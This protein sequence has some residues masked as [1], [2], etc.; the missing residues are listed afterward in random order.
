MDPILKVVNI[1]S[2]YQKHL[3]TE[4]LQFFFRY[5]SSQ[6]TLLTSQKS[7]YLELPIYFIN[8]NQAITKSKHFRTSDPLH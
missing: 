5:L 6:T 4:T 3:Q 1:C 8:V 2:K 7:N